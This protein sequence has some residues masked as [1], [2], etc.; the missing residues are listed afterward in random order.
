M[1][2]VYDYPRPCV[3][4]D[5][6]VFD[7]Y[8]DTTGRLLGSRDSD[9]PKVLLV[10]RKNEPFK[11]MWALPGG[12]LNE[13]EELEECAA[14]EL[15]EETGLDIDPNDLQQVIAVGRKVRDPRARIISVVYTTVVDRFEHDVCA[16]DDA[17]QVA[18]FS[19]DDL[20]SLAADHLD[21]I[22]NTLGMVYH[23]RS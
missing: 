13:D 7:L 2:Y 21:I 3:T 20:P 19:M 9:T 8:D 12:F 10:L 4:C 14:R 18:W 6:V 17:E 16:D 11:G 22:R 23:D 5:T 1:S 15:F